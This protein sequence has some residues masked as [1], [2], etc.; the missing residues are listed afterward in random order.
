MNTKG[1]P[2]S[3]SLCD[4]PLV[5][6]AFQPYHQVS[7]HRYRLR[8]LNAS[9]FSSYDFEFSDKR[10]M[11]QIG[12]GSALLPKPVTRTDVLLGPA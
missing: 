1:T 10:P 8:L 12:N 11:V 6:G 3:Y 5:N 4:R 2:E 9:S 7:T